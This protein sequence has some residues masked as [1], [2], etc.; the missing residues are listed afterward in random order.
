MLRPCT[1]KGA[2]SAESVGEFRHWQASHCVKQGKFDAL[3]G[4]DAIR[5]SGGQ[6]RCAI[7]TLDNARRDRA[8]GLKPVEDQVAMASQAPSDFL[9][10]AKATAHRLFAPEGE[11]LRY[12]LRVHALPESLKVFAEQT[13][14]DAHE[15][16]LPQI[17][18]L[19][20][21][22]VGEILRPFE[23]T[24]PRLGE[25]RLQGDRRNF[26]AL[27]IDHQLPEAD[28]V[29][30]GPGADHAN[31]RLVAPLVDA[32]WLESAARSLVTAGDH[33]PLPLATRLLVRP[34][35][36]PK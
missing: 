21:L 24:P 36:L 25:D 1:L 23:Q 15:I 32:R 33:E 5:F 11:K 29:G 13:G 17:G 4:S 22:A 19:R 30:R 34:T 7:K 10:R 9:H 31:G 3:S 20:G 6:S 18:E 35:H 12:P 27:R 14:L 2:S 8:R 28:R 16:L 26:V